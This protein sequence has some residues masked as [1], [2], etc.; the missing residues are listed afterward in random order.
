MPLGWIRNH[1]LSRRAAVDLRLRPRGHWDRQDHIYGK[2]IST[3]QQNSFTVYVLKITL[4]NGIIIHSFAWAGEGGEDGKDF[5]ILRF[6]K[7]HMNQILTF[8]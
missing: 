4:L 7:T 1:N 3:D 2:G 8:C 6:V 5:E